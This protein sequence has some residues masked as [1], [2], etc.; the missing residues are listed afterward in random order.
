M[1]YIIVVSVCQNVVGLIWLIVYG[2]CIFGGYRLWTLILTNMI[3]VNDSPEFGMLTAIVIATLAKCVC[4]ALCG[5]IGGI[6]LHTYGR[7]AVADITNDPST[8]TST[9]PQTD[10]PILLLLVVH[11]RFGSCRPQLTTQYTINMSITHKEI[12]MRSAIINVN[13]RR[14]VCISLVWIVNNNI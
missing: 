14:C 5:Y 10:S 1:L 3:L 8:K 12:R 13:R 7:I 11:N 2:V 6:V 9:P 4:L